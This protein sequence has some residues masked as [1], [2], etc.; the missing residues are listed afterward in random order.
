MSK[1]LAYD[2]CLHCLSM[3]HKKGA[4]YMGLFKSD[5]HVYST[6]DNFFL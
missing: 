6:Q 1:N 2:L 3:S 5:K 4:R